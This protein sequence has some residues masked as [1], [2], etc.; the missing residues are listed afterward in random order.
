MHSKSSENRVERG[1]AR[2]MTNPAVEGGFLSLKF[3]A[4]RGFQRFDSGL[5]PLRIHG[6]E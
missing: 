6:D 1:A 3:S 2:I 5:H 4:C